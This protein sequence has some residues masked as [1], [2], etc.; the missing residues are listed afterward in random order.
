M[1]LEM[2]ITKRKIRNHF[3]YSLWMY[4][5]LLVIA[6]FGW[7]LIYTTTRYRSPEN[8]K[9]EFF[10][11]GNS[12]ASDAVQKLADQIHQEVMPEMEEVT[13]T[14]VTFDD[15]YGDMQLTVWVSAGQGDVYLISRER[16]Q[17]MAASEATLPLQP[18]V[19]DGTLAVDG[20]DLSGGMVKSD[21][22]GQKELMGIPAEQLTG[23]TDYGLSTDKMVLC[24]LANNGNDT[25]SLKFLNYL[26]THL[27]A[28]AQATASPTPNATPAP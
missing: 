2:P 11:E 7:N 8:L 15:T 16:F 17:N 6:L 18:Y 25:Y 24:V 28:G 12:L 19:D 9:V 3:H 20:M 26:L 21:T 5:L 14:L 10:A 27:R 13:A 1:R 22:T 23:F 4:L